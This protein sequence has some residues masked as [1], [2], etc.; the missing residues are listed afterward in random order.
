MSSTRNYKKTPP[1]QPANDNSTRGQFPVSRSDSEQTT[2]KRVANNNIVDLRS[3]IAKREAAKQRKKAEQEKKQ[4]HT[5][6][7]KQKKHKP[8]KR[9]VEHKPK[10][11]VERK[12]RRSLSSYIV[13]IFRRRKISATRPHRFPWLQSSPIIRPLAIFIVL[14]LVIVLPANVRAMFHQQSSLERDVLGASQQGFD[15]L[16]AATALVQQYKFSEAEQEFTQARKQFEQAEQRVNSINSAARALAPYIPGK[17]KQFS[18][19]TQL[20]TAGAEISAAGEQISAAMAV[21]QTA[22]LSTALN[23]ENSDAGLTD[24]LLVAHSGLSDASTHI[25]AA[26]TA[27]A[28]VDSNAVPEDKQTAVTKAQQLI[29]QAEQ[30][31]NEGVEIVELMLE[32][33]GHEKTQRH[34][35][36]FGNN[37]EIRPC[38]GGFIGSIGVFDV[39][40]GNVSTVD[41]PGGGIYDLAGQ[42]RTKVVAPQPLQ[43]INPHWNVQDANWFPHYPECAQK[44]EKFLDD[45][46]DNFSVDVV[47]SITPDVVS[48]ILEIT[49]PIDLRDKYGL[50]INADNFYDVVQNLAEQKYDENPES[51][52]IIADMTPLLFKK[53][54]D[55]AGKPD[56]LMQLLTVLKTALDHKDITVYANDSHVQELISHRN[57]AGELM[58]TDRGYLHI[59]VANIGGGKTSTLID[60]TAD[61]HTRINE[62]GSITERVTFT[63]V[64]KGPQEHEY[65]GLDNFS[66][67]RFYIPEGSEVLSAEGFTEPSNQLFKNPESDYVQDEDL[68]RISGNIS[69]NPQTHVYTNT[70]FDKQV[71]GGWMI[72][73]RGK[74][75]RVTIEYTL[76]MKLHIG[77][78]WNATD[79]YSLL[80]QKQSGLN[81]VVRHSLELPDSTIV[82]YSYPDAGNTEKQF[83]LESDYFT[84]VVLS[85]YN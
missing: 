15:H 77:G 71:V 74:S 43:L 85:E 58:S 63:M 22:D 11:T 70:E 65:F 54:F 73:E 26:H 4:H 21:I 30:G 2:S 78:V 81:M 38:A 34:L 50:V 62:D 31:V 27:L 18:S 55:A 57:W 44:I 79:H 82:E 25:T 61:I 64:H 16:N 66:F 20:I 32:L 1:H 28:K 72:T 29:P 8:L 51:K 33:L 17:G 68:Q 56:T 24:L 9:H 47:S 80:I 84:G 37:R 6:G 69:L 13:H 76:P 19:G 60:N 59:N 39:S 42:T 75:S 48:Q 41:I 52:Q 46:N 49:G 12:K 3:I 36:L 5:K 7:E 35:V 14:S 10:K 40:K 53:I 83:K 45:N 67:V 23:G